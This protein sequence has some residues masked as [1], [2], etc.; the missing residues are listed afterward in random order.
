MTRCPQTCC[1]SHQGRPTCEKA[2][3]LPDS[4][5][6]ITHRMSALSIPMPKAIVATTACT[7]TRLLDTVHWQKIVGQSKLR[8]VQGVMQ[9]LPQCYR[10]TTVA[11]F[12][13]DHSA[14]ALHDVCCSVNFLRST[15]LRLLCASTRGMTMTHLHGSMQPHNRYLCHRSSSRLLSKL[16]HIGPCTASH[17]N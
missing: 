8:I 6:C 12:C 4:D 7:S 3:K 15:H 1:C 14:Q 17:N 10:Q 2:S 13:C 11:V 16:L 5:Q 9:C